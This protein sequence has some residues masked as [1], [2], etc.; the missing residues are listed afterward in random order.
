MSLI[1][2]EYDNYILSSSPI[3][4]NIYFP[5]KFYRLYESFNTDY[6]IIINGSFLFNETNK[7]HEN[8]LHENKLNKNDD[9]LI[10][11]IENKLLEIPY[12]KNI[13]KLFIH[14]K[15]TNFY[16]NIEKLEIESNYNDIYN[17]IYQSH[18][19]KNKN[20]KYRDFIL[21][22]PNPILIN[23]S[24][25]KKNLSNF[26]RISHINHNGNGGFTNPYPS[27]KTV[28]NKLTTI[29]NI[30]FINETLNIF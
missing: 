6:K 9:E 14:T 10:Y 24:Y 13:D 1:D 29:D 27:N 21:L 18:I 26:V 16:I 30:N 28:D 7:L 15:L 25:N 22:L 8:K 2:I 20:I 5:K 4:T 19:K 17:I 23:I 11:L 3:L 12:Y